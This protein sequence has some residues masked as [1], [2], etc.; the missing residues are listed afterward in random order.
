MRDTILILR[1][2]LLTHSR[3]PKQRLEHQA[4]LEQELGWKPQGM[5]SKLLKVAAGSIQ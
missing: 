2:Q 1:H 5:T 3:G 4:I